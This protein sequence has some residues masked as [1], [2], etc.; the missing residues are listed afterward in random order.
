ML[1]RAPPPLQDAVPRAVALCPAQP[2]S[3]LSELGA[4]L[5][6]QA[7]ARH[8]ERHL[9]A[10]LH[11][12]HVLRGEGAADKERPPVRPSVGDALL[13]R[14]CLL[15]LVYALPA[16]GGGLF[17]PSLPRRIFS[18]TGRPGFITAAARL[19]KH[20]PP[21]SQLTVFLRSLLLQTTGRKRTAGFQ[22][23]FLSR[24]LRIGDGFAVR[25]R[26]RGG[27]IMPPRV[28]RS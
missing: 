6:S 28:I 13:R 22:P 2:F 3:A 23:V 21:R 14:P 26:V 4:V 12:R 15:R 20:P 24:R 27:R 8:P 19:A 18:K 9:S 1:R 25:R 7:P 11:H 10:R 5:G 17:P 16:R